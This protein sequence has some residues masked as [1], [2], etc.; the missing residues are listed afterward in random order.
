[1]NDE[2]FVEAARAFAGRILGAGLDSDAARLRFAM[3]TAVAHAP[4]DDDER[5]LTGLLAD[6]RAHFADDPDAAAELLAVGAQPVD[7]R[8]DANELAAW[9]VVANLVLNLD[10][11]VTKE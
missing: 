5:V 2:Q 6:A 11:V 4:D 8:F 10:E 7:A 3:R 9:T 1:M